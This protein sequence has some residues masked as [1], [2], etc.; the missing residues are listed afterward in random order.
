MGVKK[1]TVIPHTPPGGGAYLFIKQFLEAVDSEYEIDYIG[2][3]SKFYGCSNIGSKF[4]YTSF[5]PCS[6]IPSYAGIDNYKLIFFFIFSFFRYLKALIFCRHTDTE[7]GI[8]LLTS[9]IQ[10]FDYFFLRRIFP[11]K[12]YILLVQENFEF[13][14]LIGCCFSKI[15]AKFNLVVSISDSW[16]SYA[17]SCGLNSYVYKNNYQSSAL[18]GLNMDEMITYDALYLGGDQ[19]IK[20]FAEFVLFVKSLNSES[21][22][23]IAVAGHISDKNKEK[24]IECNKGGFVE[25]DYI[26][27]L[28][29]VYNYILKSKVLLLPIVAPHFCRPAIESGLCKRTFLIKSHKGL[30]DFV[31]NE[32]NCLTYSSLEDMKNKFIEIISDDNLRDRLSIANYSLAASFLDDN[33][34]KSIELLSKISEMSISE[35]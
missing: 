1:I 14:G 13:R 8:V 28:D 23:K 11:N 16:K 35:H 33:N 17:S 7:E 26:G 34:E 30:D 27:Q 18:F 2:Q 3:Y 5:F 24:L 29:S 22:V 20:G 32:V 10:F 31:V 25:I 4:N 9:S 19:R 15:F 21:L 12:K 6:I